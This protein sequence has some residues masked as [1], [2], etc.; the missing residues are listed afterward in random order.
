MPATDR[1]LTRPARGWD[2][3]IVGA[4][5]AGAVLAARLSEAP[6]RRV[7]LL[8]AGPG[9]DRRAAGAP[10]PLGQPVLRGRNWD[11]SALIGQSPGRERRYPY[12]IGRGD[13]GSSAVNGAIA[14]RG[15]PGD[16]D[17]WA[18]AGNGDWAWDRVAGYFAR[19]ETD[20]DMADPRHGR[21]GPIPIRRPGGADLDT[22]AAAFVRAGKSLG[23]PEL[24]D[25]NAGAEAGVGAV[26]SNAHEQRRVSTADAYLGPARDRPNLVVTNG[27]HVDRVLIA[28][29]RAVG[30]DALLD[31]RRLRIPAGAVTLCAGAVNTPLILQRSGVGPPDRL[32][33]LDVAPVVALPGVGANLADHPAVAIWALPEPGVCRAGHPWHQ[34]MARV[35]STGREVDLNLFLASNVTAASLPG[36]ADVL[37]GRMAVAVSA[38][39]L[40]PQSR[41]TVFISGPGPLDEPRIVLRLATAPAD[42]Q[43]LMHG[44]RLA[45][46]LL[47]SPPMREL[48]RSTLLW[49]DRLVGDDALLRSA[50]GRF[51]VPMWHPTGT[52]RMGA[53]DDDLAVVD[54]RCRVHQITGLRVVDASVMPSIPSAPT[55]LTCI[56]L[57][58]RVAG[59]M[60]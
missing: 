21:R 1:A 49:T 10:P 25:L 11:Y 42:M 27:C 46:S 47:R 23:L 9:P 34:V 30:V 2:E 58:E 50:I 14:L 24:P 16:F 17:G 40:S 32:A 29:G 45:W 57:A 38:V 26:P 60:R 39:L 3:V 33:A 12:L 7:L 44:T 59:W 4:G 56:M 15:L 19:L 54:Q 55:N 43:R 5:S 35:S 53:A 6:D 18:A 22:V 31:G 37:G 13:G 51:A 28:D 52:A 48:L 20:V 36:T 8:E 41:G